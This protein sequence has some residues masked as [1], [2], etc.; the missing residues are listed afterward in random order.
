MNKNLIPQKL[1]HLISI[2]DEWGI[3]DDGYRDEY[4]ENT[5]D[6]K[7]MEFTNSITEEELSYINDWLCDNSDL[8]NIE[9]YEKFTSLYMD[10][11]YAESVLKSRKNI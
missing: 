6:Q 3:G 5:S 2:A 7:L 4:I 9:E 10:F 8:V 1:H 11:E